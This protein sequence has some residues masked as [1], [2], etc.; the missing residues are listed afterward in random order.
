LQ[1]R[2]KKPRLLM[3]RRLT[4]R[5]RLP[6]ASIRPATRSVRQ[7]PLLAKRPHRLPNKRMLTRAVFHVEHGAG[8]PQAGV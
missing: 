3:R 5:L 6:R 7:R 2:L 4:K 8:H 1:L